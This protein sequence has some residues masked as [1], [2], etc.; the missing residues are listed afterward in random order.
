MNLLAPLLALPAAILAITLHEFA[1]AW[2]IQRSG[3]D[4]PQERGR[5]SLDPAVHIEPLGL[6]ILLCSS[7]IGAPLVTWGRPVPF[8]RDKLRDPK[9]DSLRI[10]LAGP[11]CNLVQAGVWMLLL[12]ATRLLLPEMESSVWS[13]ILHLQPGG[14]PQQ[15]V[16]AVMA[17][18]VLLNICT[19]AFNLIPLP[20]LDGYFLL[21]ERGPKHW[22]VFYARLGPGAYLLLMASVPALSYLLAP[23]LFFARTAV[24]MA[25]GLPLTGR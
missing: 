11:L 4:T 19:A 17:A 22:G 20:P 7:L 14:A 23:F 16:C 1:H 8:D 3:D 21:R 24:Q 18:G 15:I 10:H 2:V 6:L 9:R 13:G 12:L 25:A 5:L